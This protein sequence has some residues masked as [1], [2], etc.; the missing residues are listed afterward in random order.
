MKIKLFLLFIFVFILFSCGNNSVKTPLICETGYHIENNKC[1]FNWKKELCTSLLPEEL[2]E[3]AY[4]VQ[5]E[6]IIYFTE[7]IGWSKPAKCNWK[8]NENYFST[9][10]KCVTEGIK[11]QCTN[12]LPENAHYSSPNEDGFI[13]RIYYEELNEY[14]PSTD[15][16]NWDCN[17]NFYKTENKCVNEIKVV[18]CTN[19]L[20]QNA[21][22]SESNANGL[23]IQGFNNELNVYEPAP[24]SCSFDCLE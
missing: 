15:S 11:S 9:S 20:P 6:V 18:N 21:V 12:I 5:D 17:E 2:P 13:D 4:S 23:L 7:N 14:F 22:W 3:N 19:I 10:T 16:C 1:V 24:D 8:C